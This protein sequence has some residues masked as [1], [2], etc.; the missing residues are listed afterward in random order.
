MKCSIQRGD[1]RSRKGLFQT[2]DILSLF[3]ELM[4]ASIA[5]VFWSET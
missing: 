4:N 5:G 1:R 3:V 2:P